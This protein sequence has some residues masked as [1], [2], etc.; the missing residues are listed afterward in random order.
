MGATLSQRR[1]VPQLPS[2]EDARLLDLAAKTYRRQSPGSSSILKFDDDVLGLALSRVPY[3]DHSALAMCSTR[4]RMLVVSDRFASL[5]QQ[6]GADECGLVLLGAGQ[7]FVCLSHS[8][9]LAEPPA[10]D[11]YCECTGALDQEKRLMF[12]VDESDVTRV[13]Y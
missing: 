9:H 1:P 4:L 3:Q 12:T 8:V 10:G 11:S 5:R 2:A 7:E 6:I 13:Y